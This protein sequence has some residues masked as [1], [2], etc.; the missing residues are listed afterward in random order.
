M[1]VNCQ[2]GAG[3]S[4]VYCCQ[5]RWGL[6]QHRCARFGYPNNPGPPLL[7]CK[8]AVRVRD[9]ARALKMY[10]NGTPRQRSIP[11]VS[12]NVDFQTPNAWQADMRCHG[13]QYVAA[14]SAIHCGPCGTQ[15]TDRVDEIHE[16]SS[17]H[18]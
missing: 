9:R 4:F 3:S 8:T 12:A 5:S 16:H 7:T 14:C 18:V 17:P 13:W 10:L 2:A 15:S 1:A 6:V 11:P